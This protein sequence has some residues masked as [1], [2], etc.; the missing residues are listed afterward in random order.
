M[1]LAP[2][3]TSLGEA[4]PAT[5]SE[6]AA[7]AV[8]PAEQAWARRRHPRKKMRSVLFSSLLLVLGD[9]VAA[10]LGAVAAASIAREPW[11]ATSSVWERLSYVAPS[12]APILVALAWVLLVSATHGYEHRTAAD[13]ATSRRHALL[14][15]PALMCAVVGAAAIERVA[16]APRELLVLGL[17][18]SL[19]AVLV[20]SLLRLARGRSTRCRRV[21]LMGHRSEV[22]QLFAEFRRVRGTGAEVVGVV[23]HRVGKKVAFDVPVAEGIDSVC[24][25]VDFLDADT[26]VVLPC[27]H[28]PRDRMRRLAWDLEERGAEILV[29]PGLLDVAPGRARVHAGPGV[30]LLHVQHA[31]LAGW[32]RRL[33]KAAWE[34]S[35]AALM[36][37]LTLPLLL[38]LMLAIR[39]NSPGQAIFRQTRVG[40]DGRTFS[41]LKLRTMS[42]D[43]PEAVTDLADRDEGAGPLFKL[44][45]DPRITRLGRVLRKY[46]LDELPQLVNVLRGDMSLIGPRPP[47]PCEVA[48][49]DDLVMRRLRVKPGLT[50]AWQVAG[51]SDL[52]WEESVRLDLDYVDNWSV[53]TDVSILARTPLAVLGHR[54]AY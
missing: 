26:L 19:A 16:I 35:V 25:A 53:W 46:S 30:P 20:R 21:V 49:Y 9:L 28:V 11:T 27:R 31:E 41:L 51:R 45:E 6:R 14:L 3:R 18:T 4:A 39:L 42:R 37:M 7:R 34:R 8:Y 40:L 29:G 33:V 47:L 17:V 52:S 5:T 44:R 12:S 36:L 54:G 22:E 1:T 10:S 2:E 50:G 38:G 32:R 23:L 24:N 43:A 13:P 48:A 15:G